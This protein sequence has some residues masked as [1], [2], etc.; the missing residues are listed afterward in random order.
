MPSSTSSSSGS[1]EQAHS[2]APVRNGTLALL[3]A[4]L[5]VSLV[6]I[7]LASRIG[8]P[9]L[10]RIE[11][12]IAGELAAARSVQQSAS[13]PTVLVVGNSLLRTDVIFDSVRADLA[14]AFDAS[15]LVVEQTAFHDWYYGLKSFFEAGHRPNVAVVMLS[16]EDIVMNAFRGAYSAYYLMAPRDVFSLA[17]ELDLHPT[18]AS[19]YLVATA[20]GFYGLRT[21]IRKNLLNKLVPPVRDLAPIFARRPSSRGEARSDE[22]TSAAP[23]ARERLQRLRDIATA[24]GVRL[25]FAVA[26]TTVGV[27]RD[28]YVLRAARELGITVIDTEV[29]GPYAADLFSDRQH[30]NEP[31]A[32]RFTRELIAGLRDVLA[33][34]R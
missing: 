6:G 18:V 26:P 3:L 31:G 30:M 25:V 8:V 14:P 19:E 15:R 23:L 27:P 32:A 24:N 33:Q 12:R 13:R 1:H 29:N 10:G 4:L 28:D 11:R 20:S 17:R 5:A 2:R 21:E 9:R 34:P 16:R 22:A 7:E